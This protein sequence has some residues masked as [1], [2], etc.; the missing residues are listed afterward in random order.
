MR[1]TNQLAPDQQTI[2]SRRWALWR[3]LPLILGAI[4]LSSASPSGG[5]FV[6][7]KLL[8]PTET[9][10]YVQI[11]GYVHVEPW[12][13]PA[14][15]FPVGADSDSS[16]RVGSGVFTEW[17]DLWKYGGIKLHSQ[18]NRAG[19][20]DEFPKFDFESQPSIDRQQVRELAG[21]SFVERAENIVLLGPPGVGKTHLAIALGV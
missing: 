16:K 10:Y 13:L 18:L 11:G 6:R 19:G 1:R 2:A 7:F 8:E 17:F 9:N 3:V 14:T 12:R 20:I 5:V 4:A 15:V 21:L